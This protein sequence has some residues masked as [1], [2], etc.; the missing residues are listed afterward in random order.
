M[1]G[2]IPS[3]FDPFSK[4]YKKSYDVSAAL[5]K[6]SHRKTLSRHLREYY[7]NTVFAT[8]QIITLTTGDPYY[9]SVGD[10]YKRKRKDMESCTSIGC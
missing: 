2:D 1:L 10:F 4:S 6:D 3:F 9:K 7:Y 8:S 5:G